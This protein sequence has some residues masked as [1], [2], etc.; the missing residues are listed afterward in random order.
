[1]SLAFLSEGGT[2]VR[3]VKEGYEDLSIGVEISSEHVHP[4]TLVMVKQVKPP[5]PPR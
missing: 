2:P 5:A 4:I 3:V 1:V